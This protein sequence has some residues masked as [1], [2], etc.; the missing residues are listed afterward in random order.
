M[1][2]ALVDLPGSARA[3]GSAIARTGVGIAGVAGVVVGVAALRGRRR[4]AFSFWAPLGAG[5]RAD[6]RDGPE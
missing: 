4:L 3:I 5:Q 1:F 2:G 6:Q